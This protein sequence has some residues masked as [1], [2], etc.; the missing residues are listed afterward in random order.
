LNEV[1]L[2]NNLKKQGGYIN[3]IRPGKPTEE[4]LRHEMFYIT[5]LGAIGLCIIALL[6]SYVTAVLNISRL[7]FMGTSIII[8]VSVIKETWESW[9]AERKGQVYV[10]SDLFA[11][12]RTSS[13]LSGTKRGVL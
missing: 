5:F 7:S 4:Y 12:S 8:T 2:S 6:P 1:E 10:Q 13:F 3:G 9:V 11:G